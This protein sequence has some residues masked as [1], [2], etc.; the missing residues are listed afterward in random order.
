MHPQNKHKSLLS[1][2]SSTFMVSIGEMWFTPEVRDLFLSLTLEMRFLSDMRFM[3]LAKPSMLEQPCL[4]FPCSTTK[5][6]QS[7]V[8]SCKRQWWP[9]WCIDLGTTC[10]LWLIWA[11]LNSYFDENDY[12]YRH[13]CEARPSLMLH[14]NWWKRPFSPGPGLAMRALQRRDSVDWKGSMRSRLKNLWLE[15]SMEFYGTFLGVR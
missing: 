13:R 3:A 11:W 2:A 10:I 14:V 15:G 8:G 6:L 12:S 7:H 5:M 4:Q 1:I 9:C